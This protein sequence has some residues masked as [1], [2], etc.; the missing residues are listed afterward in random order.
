MVCCGWAFSLETGSPP[1]ILGDIPDG[2][3]PPPAPPKPEFIVPAEGI[4][5]SETHEQG[6]REITIQ[7]ITP[8]DL[9][10]PPE[11]PA[12]IAINDPALLKRIA[13][14][15]AKYPDRKLLLVGATVYQSKD[16]PPRTLIQIWPQAEG[17]PITFWSSAD[18]SLLSGLPSFTIATGET[19]SLM[20]TWSIT[21]IDHTNALQRKYARQFTPP[22]IPVF[23]S[24]NATFI[25]TEGTPTEEALVSIRSLHE[26]YNNEHDRLLAA[27]QG[28]ER[29]RIA[30]EAELKAHPPQ[31]KDITLNYW[32]I[33][34]TTPA[35]GGDK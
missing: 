33:G 24:G 8:I 14:R 31:P 16:T 7:K 9:P 4:L 27:Y 30:Q 3:P 19:T 12:P 20:M 6:G 32:E 26:I 13:A 5:E 11:A 17:K 2:T 29:A 18:F 21:D 34:T 23:P 25:V 15:R 1:R 28:R 22:K 35:K 10:P